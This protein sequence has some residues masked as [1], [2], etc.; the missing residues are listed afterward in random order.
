MKALFKN[1]ADA[2]TIIEALAT[3]NDDMTL[4]EWFN[5]KVCFGIDEFISDYYPDT[6]VSDITQEHIDY[7]QNYINTDFDNS[8]DA[9]HARAELVKQYN[10]FNQAEDLLGLNVTQ[11]AMALGIPYRTYYKWSTG[12]QKAPAVGHAA[13]NMLLYINH[14]GMLENWLTEKRSSATVDLDEKGA[15]K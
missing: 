5:D 9:F 4:T 12:E 10:E 7:I 11:M 2:E 6:L 13:L 1:D 14:I 15:D 3:A 8:S